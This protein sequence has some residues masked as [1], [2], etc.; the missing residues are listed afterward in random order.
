METVRVGGQAVIEGV[1]MRMKDS[2]AIAVRKNKKIVVKKEEYRSITNKYSFLKIPVLRGVVFVIEMMIIGLNALTWSAEKQDEEVTQVETTLT[3]LISLLL[4]VGLFVVFPYWISGFMFKSKTLSFNITDGIL[5]LIIFIAYIY[6][7]G[8]WKDVARIFQYHGAEHKTVNCY[9]AG[10]KLTVRNCKKFTTFHPRCG[11]SL[12]LIIVLL[13]IAVFSF[14]ST[15]HWYWNVSLRILLIPAIAGL[16]YELLILCAKYKNSPITKTIM[17][18]GRW[19]QALTTKEPDD[20]QLEVAIKSLN[21]VI[22]AATIA[23][24]YLNK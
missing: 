3:L 2:I 15:G 22:Y 10:E 20:S 12:L 18:P 11:T 19:T 16:S 21:S 4:A 13:S 24:N 5:R 23:K 7:I 14:V 8:Q 6:A 1:M 9:E 17:L